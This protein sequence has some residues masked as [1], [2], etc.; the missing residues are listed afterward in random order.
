M[1]YIF[2][3]NEFKPPVLFSSGK[4]RSDQA[5][6]ENGKHRSGGKQANK[7]L[8]IAAVINKADSHKTG[9]GI[10][11][12]DISFPEWK[13]FSVLLFLTRGGDGEDKSCVK[14]RVNAACLLHQMDIL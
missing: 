11:E 2:L 9:E 5:V 8:T 6:E 1:C 14:K 4:G 13:V 3:I 7:Y 12:R 10:R